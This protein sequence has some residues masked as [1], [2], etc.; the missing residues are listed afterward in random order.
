MTINDIE[1]IKKGE[2]FLS[3][4]KN[5]TRTQGTVTAYFNYARCAF[6]DNFIDEDWYKPTPTIISS[7]D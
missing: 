6:S 5:G 7:V 2:S 1:R 3:V 4:M